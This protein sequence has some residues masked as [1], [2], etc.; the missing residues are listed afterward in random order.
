[1]PPEK[2][3]K[4]GLP[5]RSNSIKMSREEEL[6]MQKEFIARKGVTRLA[7]IEQLDCERLQRVAGFKRELRERFKKPDST[8]A[9]NDGD[10][11]GLGKEA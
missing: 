1:M 6:K 11:V 3:P 5:A 10:A 4:L 2:S 7:S 8:E 9:R